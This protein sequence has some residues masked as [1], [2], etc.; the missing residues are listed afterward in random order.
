MPGDAFGSYQLALDIVT[1]TDLTDTAVLSGFQQP[2]FFQLSFISL[3]VF[4]KTKQNETKQKLL[5]NLKKRFLQGKA[6]RTAMFIK[7]GF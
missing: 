3:F 1:N 5:P 7:F 2:Y 4:I 6:Y